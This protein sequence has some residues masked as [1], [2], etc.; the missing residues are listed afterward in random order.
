MSTAFSW[1]ESRRNIAARG[2]PASSASCAKRNDAAAR[3]S[4]ASA[5][6]ERRPA[7]E[8]SPS[9]AIL[10]YPTMLA[11]AKLEL[12][13]QLRVLALHSLELVTRTDLARAR[14]RRRD[15][16]RFR[17]LQICVD[18]RHDDARFHRHQIDADQ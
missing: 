15:A 3:K 2:A 18:G 16:D 7:I 12:A 9:T 6:P 5:K 10:R 14:H 17:V 1:L 11:I 4:G 13:A 8:R